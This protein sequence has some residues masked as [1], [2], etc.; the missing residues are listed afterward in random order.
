[1]K[2]SEITNE[3]LAGY[4]KLEYSSLTTAEKTE[5]TTLIGVAKAFIRGYTGIQEKTITGEEIGEGDGETR[6]FSTCRPIISNTPS[7]TKLYKDGVETTTGF[8]VDNPT[9]HITFTTAPDNRV[10]LTADYVTGLDAYEDF[11]IV[12]YVLCQDMYDNRTY[13]VDKTN[14]N[15]VVE[16]ILGMH[17]VNLL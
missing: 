1:M 11:V 9:G 17:C 13:Y 5:L 3:I 15:R 6:E 4:L 14:L 8:T 10:E 12:V 7:T 2:V 16:A